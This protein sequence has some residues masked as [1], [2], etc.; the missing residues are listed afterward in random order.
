MAERYALHMKL[1][2]GQH[3]QKQRS[4]RG[5][6]TLLTTP[7]GE[8]VRCDEQ[9]EVFQKNVHERKATPILNNFS[10]IS[11]MAMGYAGR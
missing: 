6:A 1:C 5:T 10:P 4:G 9:N 8:V 7:Q 3:R 2:S 11:R